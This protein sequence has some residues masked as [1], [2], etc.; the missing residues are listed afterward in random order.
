ML[1]DGGTGTECERRGVPVLDGAWSGS[2]ALSHPEILRE[3]HRDY[4]AAGAEVIIANTFSTHRHAL[5]T[6]GVAA[7]FT[8]YNRRGV[9]LA[10]QARAEA[11]ADE[12]VVAAGISNWTWTGPHPTLD[13]LR[14]QTVE[15]AAVL[16]AAGA[17]LLILEM[18]VDVARMRA[19][20][21]GAATA[22]LPVWAGLTC[23]SGDG[24]P[25]AGAG[26]R[27]RDGEPLADA[28]AALRDHDV[29][30]VAIMHTD[31]ALVDECLDVM[32]DAW[33]GPVAV[34]AHSGA[35]V[36]NTWVF[37][38]V[39]SPDDYLRHARGWFARGVRLVGGCCGTGPEHLR[40][41]TSLR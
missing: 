13:E 21:E 23:G 3:V 18:M 2:A 26:S 19:T 20:L 39:I 33:D 34:Y 16:A 32:L 40:A 28:V 25:V 5:E 8:A 1:I 10:V 31:V 17:E 24:R 4:V 38:G 6:A 37:S 15:Q 29:E 41:L 30:V 27:L 14:R 9:E 12:V 35:Y 11:G 22:G 7:D 36:D